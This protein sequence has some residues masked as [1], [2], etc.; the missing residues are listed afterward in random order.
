[1]IT[2]A[3]VTVGHTGSFNTG[4]LLREPRTLLFF[5]T[6]VYYT[7]A[8]CMHSTPVTQVWKSE[9][10]FGELVLSFHLVGAQ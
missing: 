5:L 10:D 4:F 7:K 2:I 9:D 3:T 1:M 8:L 6:F